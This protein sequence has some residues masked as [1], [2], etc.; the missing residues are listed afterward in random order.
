MT[1]LGVYIHIPFCRSQCPF[2]DFSITLR[3]QPA[4]LETFVQQILAE[5]EHSAP[6]WA[7]FE[8]A[9]TV[10]I[11]GGTPSWVPPHIIARILET[12]HRV[13][14]IDRHA[15]ITLECNPED[16]Q[17]RA[18]Q[19]WL[20]AGVNRF[21]LGIQ[22]MQDPELAHLG[23]MHRSTHNRHALDCLR[24]HG[25]KNLSVDLMFGTHPQSSKWWPQSFAQIAPWTPEHI[26]TYELTIEP[27]TVFYKK[28]QQNTLAL[29]SEADQAAQFFAIKDLLKTAGYQAYEISNAARDGKVAKHN[30]H[31]WEGG[32]YWG[33]GPSAHGRWSDGTQHQ[34]VINPHTFSQY[35]QTPTHFWTKRTHW[36]NLTQAQWEE[37]RIMT[38]LR[39]ETGIDYDTLQAFSLFDPAMQHAIDQGLAAGHLQLQ[40]I[41]GQTR[42]SLPSQ[43]RIFADGWAQRLLTS[44]QEA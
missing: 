28:A 17:R 33:L 25:V 4:A 38:G 32:A 24:E 6:F 14:G 7:H 13:H 23:R 1:G 3:R 43:Q 34:R 44:R 15:E 18:V 40:Q 41:H 19:A 16:V 20:A 29:P 5:L 37:E 22:S 12:L 26:S 27:K 21:S 42:L 30:L 9:S 35:I 8:Q 11:G 2:C 39:L 10:F 36:T 31:A